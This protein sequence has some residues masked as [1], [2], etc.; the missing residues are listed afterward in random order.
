MNEMEANM[1]KL[2]IVVLGIFGVIGLIFFMSFLYAVPVYFLW[3]WL[4]PIIF[5]LPKITFWQSIGL[6]WFSGFLIK[7]HNTGGNK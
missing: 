4:M 3:N 6:C 5:E 1:N 2:G 7:S